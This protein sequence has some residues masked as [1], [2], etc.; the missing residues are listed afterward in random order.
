MIKYS[1]SNY[2]LYIASNIANEKPELLQ[3]TQ[4][5]AMQASQQGVMSDS[6][7]MVVLKSKQNIQDIYTT[8]DKV[9]ENHH[10]S[11]NLDTFSERKKISFTPEEV[12]GVVA[13]EQEYLASLHGNLKYPEE[14]QN[15]LPKIKEAYNLQKDNIISDLHRA[16]KYSLSNN[17]KSKEEI[18]GILQQ[19]NDLRS[20][21][22]GLDRLCEDHKI[23][24]SLELFNNEKAESKS[25]DTLFTAITQ[26]QNFLHDLNK[27]IKYVDR[28]EALIS[29]ITKASSNKEDNILPKLQD[30][31]KD[32]IG[33]G[34]RDEESL[35]QELQ[36]T[37]D[38]KETYVSLDQA[39]ELH[40]IRS[41]LNSFREE[42]AE[43]KTP[44]EIIVIIARE[45]EYLSNLSD[46]LKYPAAYSNT[47]LDSVK[48][49][50][51]RKDTIV[52][53][54]HQ[55]TTHILKN[56]VMPEQDLVKS[57][58]SDKDIHA[59]STELVKTCK[60]HHNSIVIKNVNSIIRQKHL[61]IH[62]HKFDC[63]IKYLE[64]EIA[65]PSHAYVDIARLKRDIP[66][67]QEHI[68][69]MALAKEMSKGMGGMS[70]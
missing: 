49:A 66:R 10:L 41:N 13:K 57:L 15:L 20:D 17:I 9:C 69:K 4:K 53:E 43:A 51:E 24:T 22:V 63:P 27:N 38:L 36:K 60:N 44:K 34:T 31:T 35:R 46:N 45:Q 67:V 33:S 58:Q 68:H 8:I 5:I 56:Q 62:G 29:L 3:N 50:R 42:K 11:A 61:E 1:L 21:Y 54:L 32:I 37:T 59:T 65:N 2:P 30:L 28:D 19:T 18:I 64:H 39:F 70:M 23:E 6:E 16:V 48:N 14:Q 52:Q 40:H 7:I 25:L 12:L 47:L 55:L 26:E